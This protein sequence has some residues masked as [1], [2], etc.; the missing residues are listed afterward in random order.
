MI[1]GLGLTA[2]FEIT[3]T[4]IFP[5]NNGHSKIYIFR[6]LRSLTMASNHDGGWM[7][8]EVN[9]DDSDD[10]NEKYDP[11]CGSSDAESVFATFLPILR[12]DPDTGVMLNF[13]DPNVCCTPDS[14]FKPTRYD[15]VK[16]WCAT[17]D[18]A[19]ALH[20]TASVV[21]AS[22]ALSMLA[23]FL[24]LRSKLKDR[25]VVLAYAG[26][27]LIFVAGLLHL[28]SS[29]TI[30]HWFGEAYPSSSTN[31]EANCFG[32]LVYALGALMLLFSCVAL[33]IILYVNWKAGNANLKTDSEN[34]TIQ[35]L[36]V[37]KSV[38]LYQPRATLN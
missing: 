15:D 23:V 36:P 6:G 29:L 10:N 5:L 25:L 24:C 20:S 8:V 4:L 34:V 13:T 19:R 14:L 9:Y 18:T 33:A 37:E 32:S 28:A 17:R 12:T 27:A 16:R 35:L 2:W 22:T 31:F 3:S 21:L 30:A 11:F 26:L 1:L 38:N 7:A